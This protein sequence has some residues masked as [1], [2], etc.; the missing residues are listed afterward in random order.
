MRFSMERCWLSFLK[1]SFIKREQSETFNVHDRLRTSHV[2]FYHKGLLQI[3]FAEMFVYEGQ[4]NVQSAHGNQ[5]QLTL[6]TTAFYKNEI[7]QTHYLTHTKETIVPYLHTLLSKLPSS[8]NILKIWS[9]GPT[10]QFENKYIA[11]TIH[12]LE[13]KVFI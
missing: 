1:H 4:D 3:G 11:T 2:E 9:D 6:F 8:L 7:F 5:R 12:G 10:S 13:T